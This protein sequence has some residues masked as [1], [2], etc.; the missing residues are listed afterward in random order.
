M[1]RGGQT[2]GV[3]FHAARRSLSGDDPRGYSVAYGRQVFEFTGVFGSQPRSP[4]SLTL[5]A[6]TLVLRLVARA[7]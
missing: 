1:S 7:C 4:L 3:C 5:D 6:N 2:F